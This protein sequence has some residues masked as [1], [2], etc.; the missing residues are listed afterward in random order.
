MLSKKE[1]NDCIN[2]YVPKEDQ[3]EAHEEVDEGFNS[4]D[5]NG[6]GQ[7]DE[8]EAEAAFGSLAQLK[9]GPSAADLIGMCDKNGDGQLSKK[10]INACIDKYDD[11]ADRA[12][13][14]AEVDSHFAEADTDGNGKL[15]AAEL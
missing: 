4:V 10:E 5:T 13:D 15:D 8:A 7:I 14:K 3:K 2:K 9:Q 11:P 12:A 1:I 6:D